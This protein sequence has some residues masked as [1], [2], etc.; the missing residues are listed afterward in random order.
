MP[1]Y[2]PVFHDEHDPLKRRDVLHWIASHGH[3]IRQHSG[4]QMAN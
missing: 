2:L 3:D 1:E 4:G